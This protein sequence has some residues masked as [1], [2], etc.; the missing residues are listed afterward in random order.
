MIKQVFKK[1]HSLLSSS[2]AS[3][4]GDEIEI[5]PDD[6][7]LVSYPKSGNTWVRFLVGNYI[8]DCKVDFINSHLILPDVHFNPQDCAKISSRPRFIKSHKSFISTYPKVVYIVRD[9]RD[10]A[11]S[12]YFYQI[13]IGNFDPNI[14]FSIFL[15]K[16][17]EK[18]FNDF[19]SWSEHVQSWIDKKNII[20]ITYEDLLDDAEKQLEKILLF[21][22]VEV[23]KNR[24]SR[25]VKSSSFNH[26]Q[27]LEV[28]QHDS[29]PPLMN[30]KNKEIQFMRK[31]RSGDWKSHFIKEDE[32]RFLNKNKN[33]MKK[34]GY[35]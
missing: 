10:V 11:V 15:E 13:K 33:I 18:G 16:F 4:P 17:L 14:P 29:S 35:I 23:D 3:I 9:G 6:V 32:E 26:M 20:L 5:F 7:F 25:A 8:T 22:N 2:P 21:S 28:K 30:V 19:G 24:I 34:L 31:G 27:K 1:L 12:Y